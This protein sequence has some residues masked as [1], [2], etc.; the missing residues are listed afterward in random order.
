MKIDC[1]AIINA[2]NN[3][4][5]M[6]S[7]A[8]AF[9]THAT[10]IQRILEKNDVILRHDTKK[11]GKLYVKDGEK[12]IEWAKQQDRLVTK[13]ELAAIIGR[14]KLSPSYFIKYPELGQYIKSPEQKELQIYS[15]KLYDWLKKNHILYKPNDRTKLKFSVSA[16]LLQDYSNIIIHIAEKPTYVSKITHDKHIKL[17]LNRANDLGINVIFL[18]KDDFECLDKLKV[19]L[20]ELTDLKNK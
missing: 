8:H 10:T 2:Y 3:G 16:L 5:S 9:K 6:N 4:E 14:K 12:L 20:D 7:I 11:E 15:K 1:E 17:I 18:N 13:A 19:S